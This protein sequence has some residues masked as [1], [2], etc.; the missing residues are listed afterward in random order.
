MTITTSTIW[1][2]TPLMSM[3]KTSTS[4]SV[5]TPPNTVTVGQGN[6]QKVLRVLEVDQA[7]F[8]DE[9][10][11]LT[12]QYSNTINGRKSNKIRRR[13]VSHKLSYIG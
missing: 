13:P 7:T 9:Q 3:I 12:P 8:V 5:P 2:N 4:P 10:C 1:P 11:I 6:E